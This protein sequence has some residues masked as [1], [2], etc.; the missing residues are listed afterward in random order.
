M[1]KER[2][3]PIPE[4]VGNFIVANAKG[5]PMADGT[6]YHYAEVCQLLKLYLKKQDSIYLIYANST[7]YDTEPYV[8]GFSFTEEEADNMVDEKTAIY[9]EAYKWEK[10]LQDKIQ[11]FRLSVLKIE[12]EDR[13]PIKKWEKGIHNKDI[14]PAMRQER[15]DTIKENENI[16]LRNTLKN[17]ERDKEELAYT[18]ELFMSIPEKVRACFNE[19]RYI[20]GLSCLSEETPYVVRKKTNG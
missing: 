18:E 5:T 1:E 16:G 11:E 2:L 17:Q 3:Y 9:H 19:R 10:K 8:V 15:D 14:T 12:L 4:P 20:I 13:I 6:Y 7:D